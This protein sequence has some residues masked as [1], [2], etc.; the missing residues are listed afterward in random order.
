MKHSIALLLFAALASS[1]L[2]PAQ[3]VRV[4]NHS[5]LPFS[6]WK[7]TT[8]DVMPPHAVGT[9]DGALYAVGR[10]VG[11]DT[12][13]VDLR[14]TLAPGEQRSFDLANATASTWARGPFP[15]DPQQAFGGPLTIDG[16]AFEWLGHIPDGAGYTMHM[17]RRTSPMVNVELWATWY[18]D[19]PAWCHGEVIIAASSPEVPDLSADILPQFDLRFGDSLVL[20]AGGV[21]FDLL[22][23]GLHLADGQARVLPLT[24]VWLQHLQQPIDWTS[25]W[26]ATNLGIGAVGISRLLV[27]GNP[28]YPPSFSAN[29]WR[30]QNMAEAMRRLHTM[31]APVCGPATNSSIAGAQE[32]QVFV[33]GEALL[34][35]GVG[36]EWIT[37]LSAIKYAARPCHHLEA[38]GSP[39]DP[40]LHVNPRL[41]LFDGRVHW[42]HGVS[43][44]RL[45]KTAGITPDEAKGWW[46]PDVE[47]WFV[48]TLAAATRLTGSPACQWLLSFQAKIYLLTSTTQQGL[49]TSQVYAARA[50]GW[51]GINAVH[52]WREL[53]DR[54]LANR[55]QQHWQTRVTTVI[56]PAYGNRAYHVWDPRLDD[57]RLGKGWWYHPWQQA[58]GAYGLDL[59]C[60][61][62][63]PAAGRVLAREA[64]EMVVRSSFVFEGG[65]WLN[66]AAV[67][68]DG[69][70]DASPIFYLFGT[71]LAPAVLLRHDPNHPQARAIWNQMRADATTRAHTA[72]LAPGVF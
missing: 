5:A 6:G 50:V 43:P 52:Y 67:S 69:R 8:V 56:L 23:H 12:R 19:Q 60:A 64:A 15:V 25:A 46:G 44:E 40:A 3:I 65:V 63:G 47:H 31:E 24:M 13:V 28:T 20:P 36:A 66:R 55:V 18:P 70:Y 22:P 7:R 41:V 27:D 48:N 17:R 68:L 16:L 11:S 29:A 30:S 71:P 37:Y 35:G 57:I 10:S 62:L 61:V 72:W 9:I 38:D 32:D 4:A 53:E 1:A 26:V 59:G 51:E 49:A 21:P 54:N 42:H 14:V 58:V 34:P 39:L 33:R 2:L 45:G